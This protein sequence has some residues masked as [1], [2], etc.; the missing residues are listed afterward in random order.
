MRSYEAPII[1]S[2]AAIIMPTSVAGSHEECRL[3][4]RNPGVSPLAATPVRY[5]S[6]AGH[7]AEHQLSRDRPGGVGGEKAVGRGT[8]GRVRV[9]PSI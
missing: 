9:A 4:K 6:G 5:L 3:I 8:G 2:T 7:L 1:P